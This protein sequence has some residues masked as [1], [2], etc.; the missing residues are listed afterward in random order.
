MLLDDL[1]RGAARDAHRR[2][3]RLLLSDAGVAVSVAVGPPLELVG[4][5]QDVAAGAWNLH[6]LV[7]LAYH[8][9]A[10]PVAWY[11]VLLLLVGAEPLDAIRAFPN[12]LLWHLVFAD[13]LR[14]AL[15][16]EGE[17]AALVLGVVMH[18]ELGLRV[19]VVL[20]L[21]RR[22]HGVRL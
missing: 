9:V 1:L 17:V 15:A 10:L 5:L 19:A 11:L 12:A 14:A 13:D 16:V 7:D 21:D 4:V 6:E 20:R 18:E 2:H 22:R 8:L 3:V